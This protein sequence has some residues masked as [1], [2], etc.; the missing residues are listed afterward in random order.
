MDILQIGSFVGPGTAPG[1]L[2]WLTQYPEKIKGFPADPESAAASV[3][4]RLRIWARL[5][6]PRPA[7]GTGLGRAALL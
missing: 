2:P 3:T 7:L 4:S 5:R 1:H 6:R